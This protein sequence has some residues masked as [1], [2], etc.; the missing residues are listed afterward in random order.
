M[1]SNSNSA[2]QRPSLV[3]AGLLLVAGVLAGLSPLMGVVVT[4]D[5]SPTT[6][7]TIAAFVAVLPG[8]LAVVLAVRRPVLGLAATAGAGVIGVVR[9]LT[10]LAVVTEADRITR[11]ELFAETTDRARPFAAGAGGWLLLAAD[12]LWVVVGVLAA[13]RTAALVTGLTGSRPDVIFG[14]PDVTGD[15]RSDPA[16]ADGPAVAAALSE[17]QPGRRPLNLPMVSVGFVGAVLLMVGALGTPYVRRLSRPSGAAVR[18]EPDRIAGR[19]IAWVFWPPS[20]SWWPA[21]YPGRSPRH[22]WPAPRWPRPSP[23]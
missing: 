18:V 12:V 5:G 16:D 19:R 8:V 2:D 11:P 9:L 10:D 15:L 1:Q 20:S 21:R 17:P 4:A 23:A 7:A 14:G 13:V 22:C 3:L 6:A